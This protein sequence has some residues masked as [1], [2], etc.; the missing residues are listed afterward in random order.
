VEAAGGPPEA[1]P[2]MVAATTPAVN[3]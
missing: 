1:N 3:E 2:A